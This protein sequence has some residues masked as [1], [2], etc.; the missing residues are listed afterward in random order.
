MVTERR[1]GAVRSESARIAI[2]EATASQFAKHGY[3]RL[4]MEG[5]AAE[6]KVGKQTIYRWWPSR[7]ALI[8]DCLAEGLLFPDWFTPPNT[9]DLRADVT[10]W[11]ESII[12][13]LNEPG[14]S[15]LLRSLIIACAE[16]EEVAERLNERLGLLPM[17]G[18]RLGGTDALNTDL[19]DAVIGAIVLR[20]LR[21]K[22]IEPELA[23][24]LVDLLLGEG[25]A[26]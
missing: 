5:I 17:L 15:S 9:G 25:D 22:S 6:A 26:A 13:F 10:V 1:R 19:G 12:R 8:A 11:L 24:R 20:A 16:N 18:D 21:R 3:D 7:S 23:Q 4:T 14:N 2:L